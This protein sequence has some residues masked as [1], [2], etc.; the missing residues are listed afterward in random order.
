MSGC[1]R[2]RQ[3][4]HLKNRQLDRNVTI[5]LQIYQSSWPDISCISHLTKSWPAPPRVI[6]LSAETEVI[7]SFC[8]LLWQVWRRW[9]LKVSIFLYTSWQ[10]SH[11]IFSLGAWIVLRC[12]TTT[13]LRSLDLPHDAQSQ[14]SPCLTMN[15]STSLI[16]AL[17]LVNKISNS[18]E[19]PE[20]MWLGSTEQLFVYKIRQLKF[21][22]HQI[23]YT[24][25][26]NS[27]SFYQKIV[28]LVNKISNSAEQ[29]EIMWLG[30]TEQLFVY[31]L[32][33]SIE[34]FFS[35]QIRHSFS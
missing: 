6:I 30:S 20:I 3:F 25:F 32:S 18:A 5:C 35:R 23:T 4:I 12:L 29:P 26:L 14:S 34:Y 7:S 2:I 27:N 21:F 33:L 16:L 24:L 15:C 28:T 19:Q 31:K 22:S 8:L 17:A 11:L 9:Y 13:C 10:T 1:D